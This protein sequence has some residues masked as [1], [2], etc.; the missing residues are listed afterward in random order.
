MGVPV[1]EDLLDALGSLDGKQVLLRAD[2]N[3]PLRDGE[4]TDDLRIRAALPTISWLMDHGAVVTA[5]S[6]LGRPK[7]EP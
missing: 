1:L 2:F 7:G 3:V 6:H 5:C 4:I